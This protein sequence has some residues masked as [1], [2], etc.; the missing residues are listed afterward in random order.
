MPVTHEI[1]HVVQEGESLATIAQKY[2]LSSWRAIYHATTNETLRRKRPNP[3]MI[4][5]GDRVLIPPNAIDLAKIRL[6]ELNRLRQDLIRHFDDQDRQLD[7]EF[8]HVSNLAEIIDSQDTVTALL[9]NVSGL[10][11][12]GRHI[13][14]DPSKALA[15]AN[16]AFT[17][18]HIQRTRSVPIGITGSAVEVPSEEGITW[19]VT[20]PF[21]NEWQHMWSTG[22]WSAKWIGATKREAMKQAKIYLNTTRSKITQQIDRRLRETQSLI[23]ELNGEGAIGPARR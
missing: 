1:T 18:T 3:R 23:N 14:E 9:V 10:T 6:Y 8:R 15:K 4:Q 19:A 17:R 11:R 12:K 20:K 13:L 5:A 2:R 16:Q 21:L 7:A 22:N